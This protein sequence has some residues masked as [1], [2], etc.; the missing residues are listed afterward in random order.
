MPGLPQHRIH[1]SSPNYLGYLPGAEC[2]D[3]PGMTVLK[4][5]RLSF[6]P[7]AQGRQQKNEGTQDL[8]KKVRE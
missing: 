4:N 3:K 6:L 7:Q 8:V 1:N 2:C 5:L